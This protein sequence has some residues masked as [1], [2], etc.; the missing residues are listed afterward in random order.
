M[1][2]VFMHRPKGIP[3]REWMTEHEKLLDDTKIHA[4][5][6]KLGTTYVAYEV[7]PGE[8]IALTILTQYDRN[9]YMNWGY[10]PQ[11]ETMGPW[12]TDAPRKVLEALTPTDNETAIR[13][14][15]KAWAKLE[16]REAAA[17][18]RKGSVVRFT[19]PLRFTSGREYDTFVFDG[20]SNF[21]VSGTFTRVRITGWRDMAWQL[22]YQGGKAA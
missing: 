8:V 2:W 18:V 6:T 9:S 4:I 11:D 15:E 21:T 13:W 16:R 20:R 7:Q 22:L 5:G 1:G 14:R 3:E 17:K 19:Q 12:E 10:K